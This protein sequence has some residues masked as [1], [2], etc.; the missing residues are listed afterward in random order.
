MFDGDD[1]CYSTSSLSAELGFSVVASGLQ[2]E[3]LKKKN[4]PPFSP[5]LVFGD[6]FVHKRTVIILFPHSSPPE[7]HWWWNEL[8]LKHVFWLT[9][10]FPFHSTFPPPFVFSLQF[11]PVCVLFLLASLI[12]L[13]MPLLLRHCC[14]GHC[15]NRRQ[16]QILAFLPSSLCAKQYCCK[17]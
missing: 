16:V 2:S 12:S 11:D 17:L 4:I 5:A 7:K 15:H 14:S 6:I 13:P 8:L 9:Y 10:H 3:Y 1:A